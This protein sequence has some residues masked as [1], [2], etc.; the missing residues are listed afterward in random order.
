MNQPWAGAINNNKYKSQRFSTIGIDHHV[1]KLKINFVF[2]IMVILCLSAVPG[3]VAPPIILDIG[4][5]SAIVHWDPI[6]E[7]LA[8]GKI[9][10]YIINYRI[11]DPFMHSMV[12]E[13]IIGG[14]ENADRNLIVGGDQTSATLN[15]L[16][17]ILRSSIK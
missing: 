10:N 7:R 2:R 9:T 3:T 14:V 1:T 13:C 17:K 5:F 6:P 4:P 11:S 8:S 12:P 16:S 15:N